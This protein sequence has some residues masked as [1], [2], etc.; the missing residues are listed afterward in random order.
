[1]AILLI[2]ATI[3]AMFIGICLL[4]AALGAFDMLFS[5]E[6]SLIVVF[7]LTALGFIYFN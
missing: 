5:Q 1:M 3:A 7:G 2:L 4:V 6:G